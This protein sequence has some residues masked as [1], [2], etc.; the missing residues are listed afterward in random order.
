M[1]FPNVIQE[2]AENYN[3][4][5]IANYTYELVKEYNSFYQSTSVLNTENEDVKNFRVALSDMI[6]NIIK[7]AMKLLGVDVPN[8]M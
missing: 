8:Q 1:D 5:L 7:N 2:A 6:A 3:P 4:A